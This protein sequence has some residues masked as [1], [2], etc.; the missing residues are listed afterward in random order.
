MRLHRARIALFLLPMVIVSISPLLGWGADG[1]AE[2]ADAVK[3]LEVGDK[4]PDLKLTDAGSSEFDL[5]KEVTKKP[6]ALVFYR[7]GW[8]PYCNAQLKDYQKTERQLIDLGY[9]IV[10]VSPDNPEH[11]AK[12]STDQELN[13]LLISDSK[14]E[15]AKAFGVA[16]QLPEDIIDKYLNQYNLDLKAYSGESHYQLP[17]PAVFLIGTDGTI[18][19]R[20]YDPDYKK[21]LSGEDLVKAAKAALGN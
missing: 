18:K 17:V 1:V 13:Y 19:F 14:M 9:R 7:G 21:R 12:T 2:T 10:A 8:C 15:A 5:I 4:I 6:V 20:H 3:P 16:F 11:L